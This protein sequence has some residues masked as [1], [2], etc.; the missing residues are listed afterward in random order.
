M[1]QEGNN[2]EPI[3]LINEQKLKTQIVSGQTDCWVSSFKP[4]SRLKV[5]NFS[6][7]RPNWL[8]QQN[9]NVLE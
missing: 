7:V 9:I 5:R 1:Y 6:S 4:E 2:Y 8:K 3:Y